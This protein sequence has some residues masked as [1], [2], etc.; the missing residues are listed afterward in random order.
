A[1]QLASELLRLDQHLAQALAEGVEALVHARQ[2]LHAQGRRRE[3][4]RA[5]RAGR[6]IRSVGAVGGREGVSAGFGGLLKGSRAAQAIVRPFRYARVRPSE[7]TR[8]ASTSSSKSGASRSRMLASRGT[9]PWCRAKTPSTY[10]SWA[11][12]RTMP[13]RARPP[14]SRSSACASTVLPAPV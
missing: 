13:A 1:T 5:G 8:R 12:G 7:P 10:A 11:P 3:P 6:G 4:L 14:S 9:S 2:R